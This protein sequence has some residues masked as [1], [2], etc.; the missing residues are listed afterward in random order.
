MP[1]HTIIL[2]SL[3]ASK[4][5]QRKLVISSIQAHYK[6]KHLKKQGVE[7][8]KARQMG[9]QGESGVVKEGGH[10]TV[11]FIAPKLS[12]VFTQHVYP[13]PEAYGSGK[14]D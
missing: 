1:L 9:W 5:H 10:V 12:K 8:T 4:S 7:I 13:S 6:L 2:S 14:D 3:Y 11:N